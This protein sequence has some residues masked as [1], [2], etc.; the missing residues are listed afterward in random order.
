MKDLQDMICAVVFDKTSYFLCRLPY[1]ARRREN[2]RSAPHL[3]QEVQQ[4]PGV[5]S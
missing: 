3:K 5:K 2:V 1:L 4:I